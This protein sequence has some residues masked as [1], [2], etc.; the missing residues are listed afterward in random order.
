M[1]RHADCLLRTDEDHKLFAPGDSGVKQVPLE[2]EIMLR[3]KRDDHT[4][5]LGTL[6]LVD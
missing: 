6:T 1:N 3:V 5:E 2:H 4:G